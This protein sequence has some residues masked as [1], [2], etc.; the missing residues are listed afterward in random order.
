MLGAQG[1]RESA[2]SANPYTS[3]FPMLGAHPLVLP[4]ISYTEAALGW[5]KVRSLPRV[6]FR[7][8]PPED[9]PEQEEVNR[10]IS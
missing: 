2:E 1:R 3:H 7:P 10:W 8:S 4:R 5:V 9:R 6:T